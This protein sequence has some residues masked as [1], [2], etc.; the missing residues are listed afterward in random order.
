VKLKSEGKVITMV[1]VLSEAPVGVVNFITWLDKVLTF[2]ED[3]VSDLLVSE[4]AFAKFN[5]L[6][7]TI[8][9]NTEIR[10][11]TF[12]NFFNIFIYLY[13]P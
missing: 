13:S 9:A 11:N 3:I 5:G 8:S 7:K 12:S 10:L 4:A 2:E 6:A 1:S